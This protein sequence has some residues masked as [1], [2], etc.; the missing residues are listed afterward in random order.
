VETKMNPVHLSQQNFERLLKQLTTIEENNHK[1]NQ[2]FETDQSQQLLA[3][4]LQ[5]YQE[6]LKWLI[7][8]STRQADAGNQLPFVAIGSRVLVHDLDFDETLSFRLTTPEAFLQE[9]EDIT[10]L[11]PL[12]RALFLKNAGDTITLDVPAGKLHYR[13]ESIY[14]EADA[15]VESMLF[16]L[17]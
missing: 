17:T 13:I 14:L 7:E 10:P 16:T 2:R 12:G 9:G 5:Q 6:K 1:L 4:M 15:P 8:Q 3:T 11:S